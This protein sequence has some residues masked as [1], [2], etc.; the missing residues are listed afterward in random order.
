MMKWF[1]S[2]SLT[3]ARA[4]VAAEA[5]LHRR[6]RTGVRALWDAGVQLESST[7]PQPDPTSI[8]ALRREAVRLASQ[9]VPFPALADT[10]DALRELNL[11]MEQGLDDVP[12]GQ[13]EHVLAVAREAHARALTSLEVDHA[14]VQS[15]VRRRQ[16]S[17]GLAVVLGCAVAA[18]AGQWMVRAPQPVDLTAGKPFTLSTKWADCHPENYECGGM[19]M[20]VA[21]HTVQ[22]PS[23]WYM[24]DFGTP[25]TFSSAT[26]I[27]RQDMLMMRAIPLVLEVSDDGKTFTEVARRTEAFT[28]WSTSF[29]PRTARYFRVRIDRV[30][31]LH[32]EAVRVHP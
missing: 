2:E 16:V 13:V 17:A 1:W 4:R 29:P 7:A 28:T 12:A 5:A 9:A 18:I 10:G 11:L 23:P 31:T 27:N 14:E 6:V 22:D 30:S 21:F 19:P 20:R 32:L 3:A 26:I 24:V 8:A 25:T 15:L